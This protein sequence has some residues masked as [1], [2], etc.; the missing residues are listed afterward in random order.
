MALDDQRRQLARRPLELGVGRRVVEAVRGLAAAGRELDRPRGRDV[1]GV[2]RLVAGAAHLLQLAAGDVVDD[3][4]GLAGGA[5]GGEGDRRPLGRERGEAE[6]GVGEAEVAQ[7]LGAGVEHEEPFFAALA[8]DEGD[9]AVVEEGVGRAAE[10]PLRVAQLGLLGGQLRDLAALVA[11][12]VPPAVAVGDEV[13]PALGVPL[14]LED[15]LL[16][17]AGDQARVGRVLQR[18]DPELGPVP[19]HVR[20]VPAGPG[21]PA[22]VG[23][24]P[25]EGV[26]V[27]PG[28]EH[29][30]LAG[31]VE[32]EGDDLVLGF[33]L[34]V[35]LA[36]ADDRAPVRGEP[37]VGVA[38]GAG[39]LGLGADRDRL[40]AEA[41]AVEPL[42]GEVD[43]EDEVVGDQRPGA[44]AVL[45]DA[46]AG[47]HPRRRHVFRL[48]ARRPPH[49][50]HAPALGRPP[51][52][53]PDGAV[54]GQLR[55][56]Q[57]PSR[58]RRRR[59]GRSASA[60]SRRGRSKASAQSRS[61][62]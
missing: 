29:G 8:A 32:R 43:E 52:A 49:Q 23:A 36:H 41:L 12:E 16:R 59:R 61:A 54:A 46:G 5:G 47:V 55:R 45:V 19:G 27:A 34:A 10:E 57:P 37:H 14:G 31:A 3:D 44:A 40:L 28:G 22:A 24:D 53:P 35:D 21:E 50:H 42:V 58:L 20:V 62:E 33:A 9:R 11:V 17:P 15:R 39:A 2:D 1:G 38:Q 4:R 18:R 13:Q 26:E 60:R 25:G 7:A 48:A 30:R 6:R 51:F 56:R